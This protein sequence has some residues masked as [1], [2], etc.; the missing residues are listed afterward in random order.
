MKKS[1]LEIVRNYL[2]GERP[3]IQVGYEEGDK[4]R[5]FGEMWTD[6]YRRTWQ[7]RNG[8]RLNINPQTNLI[9]D[10]TKQICKLCK[11]EVGTWAT[12][13]D[14]KLYKMT[15]NCSECQIKEETQMR[16]DGTYKLYEK[17]KVYLNQLSYLEDISVEIRDRYSKI[18][19]DKVEFQNI[20]DEKNP[21]FVDPEKWS[22]VNKS[23]QREGLKKDYRMVFAEVLRIRRELKKLEVESK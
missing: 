8:Y 21:E 16:I 14:I 6:S 23:E 10:L 5:K 12:D 20:V 4:P 18:Q 3:I 22:T 7:Q 11:K 9:R 19:D 2:S 15:G 13:L 1:N 17:K